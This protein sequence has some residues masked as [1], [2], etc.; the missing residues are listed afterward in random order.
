[1]VGEV[2]KTCR[3]RGTNLPDILV[4][5]SA[6]LL[7]IC[8]RLG[9]VL[10][11]VAR[12][13]NLVLDIGGGLDNDP[14]QHGNATDDLLTQEVAIYLLVRHPPS[15]GNA[16]G[17]LMQETGSTSH[18]GKLLSEHLQ[19]PPCPTDIGLPDLDLLSTSLRV[20]FNVDIDGEM[21]VHVTHLVLVSLG[22][23][24]DQVLDERLDSAEG[25]NILS[26]TVVELDVDGVGTLGDERDGKV[27]EVLHELS[28]GS[29]DG[30]DPRLDGNGDCEF[31]MPSAPSSSSSTR[32]RFVSNSS[33]SPQ[34][35]HA[36][37]PSPCAQY[38]HLFQKFPQL[39][40]F[41][42]PQIIRPSNT[43]RDCEKPGKLTALGDCQRLAAVDVLHRVEAARMSVFV[44]E[45]AGVGAVVISLIWIILKVFV[46][47]LPNPVPERFVRPG[48]SPKSNIPA[49]QD[50]MQHSITRIHGQPR[51]LISLSGRLGP[52]CSG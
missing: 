47:L 29:G 6:D 18:V 4:P 36:F 8:S 41:R 17:V 31:D 14:A 20:L 23:T 7:D 13:H 42:S 48:V 38:I 9:H 11:G 34:T 33:Q 46:G 10:E 16:G 40:L 19:S 22:D 26:D 35:H 1:M 21:S 37:C 50:I 3:R 45:G 51:V 12:Q 27:L 39:L 30:D 25:S 32:S 44:G 24:G 2:R 52:G 49:T 43:N 5:H 28:A 15:F